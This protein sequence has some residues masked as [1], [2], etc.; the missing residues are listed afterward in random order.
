M[1]KV[2]DITEDKIKLRENALK[3]EDL[4]KSVFKTSISSDYSKCIIY[5]QHEHPLNPLIAAIDINKHSLT[6][7]RESYFGEAMEFGKKYEKQ[8]LTSD[9]IPREFEIITDYSI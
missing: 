7:Y 6:L 5:L 2:T 3:I 8:F 9:S 4:A 1:V